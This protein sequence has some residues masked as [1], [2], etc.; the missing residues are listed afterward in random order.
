MAPGLRLIEIVSSGLPV[1]HQPRASRQRAR[2]CRR[3]RGLSDDHSHR[4]AHAA[5][6]IA[7]RRGPT[8]PLDTM[9]P[10]T[11][12]ISRQAATGRWRYFV[13]SP[14]SDVD[15]ADQARGRDERIARRRNWPHCSARSARIDNAPPRLNLSVLSPPRPSH[16]RKFFAC[17]MY[18][19]SSRR[20]FI[21][22][23]RMAS[24]L[25][26]MTAARRAA[27]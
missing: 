12:L 11:R 7:P 16:C 20:V 27:H 9:P 8:A 24:P 21:D 26:S 10:K 18:R 2:I 19:R 1:R 22:A 25:L 5:T 4:R 6:S 14:V 15:S 17:L 13:A 23:S 3:G